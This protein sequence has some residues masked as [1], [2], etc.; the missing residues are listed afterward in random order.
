MLRTNLQSELAGAAIANQRHREARRRS[1]GT[2]DID[3]ARRQLVHGLEHL[4]LAE[5]RVADD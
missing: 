3:A 2:T 1:G 4:A 5:T